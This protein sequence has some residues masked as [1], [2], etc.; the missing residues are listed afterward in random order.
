MNELLY[1]CSSALLQPTTPT[2][3]TPYGERIVSVVI[4][5]T[6]LWTDVPDPYDIN[7]AWTAGSVVVLKKIVNGHRIFLSSQEIEVIHK[8]QVEKVY[9]IEGKTRK[10][11]EDICRA[12]EKLSRYPVLYVWYITDKNY[13]FGG[14]EVY[15]NFSLRIFEG[16]G[17]PMFISFSF[18][19]IDI[20]IDYSGYD[21]LYQYMPQY[22]ETGSV[23]VDSTL[24][25]VDSTIIT[26]DQT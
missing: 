16:K 26:S 21:S 24:I 3:A 1:S 19:F 14:Y 2:C 18:D 11:D 7:L 17:I 15:P 4:A 12:I 6:M 22:V 8:E 25:T 9:R 20:G 23:T 13:C 10:I 5:K